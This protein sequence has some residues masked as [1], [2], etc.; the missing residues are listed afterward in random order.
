MTTQ[1]DASRRHRYHHGDCRN[2]LIDVATQQAINGGGRDHIV[3]R[4][5]AREVGVSP[6]A[7][8]R[9]FSSHDD[10]VTAV[11]HRAL[12]RLAATMALKVRR[13]GGDPVRTL[14]ALGRA[15]VEFAVAEPGLFRV[16]FS[17]TDHDVAV[18]TGGPSDSEAYNAL[19]R[20][21]DA[22]VDAGLIDTGRRPGLELPVWSAVHGL[23]VLLI[24]GP[25]LELSQ[26]RLKL[27]IEGTLDMVLTGVTRDGP[28]ES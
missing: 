15:Y 27:A 5:A 9:H 26:R 8:Y 14:R 21:L 20:A 23:A 1:P 17:R 6:T 22:L 28:N 16:A 7:A 2:A 4:E 12:D 24:D 25:P 19:S 3:L 13:A 11:K 10:L 18:D